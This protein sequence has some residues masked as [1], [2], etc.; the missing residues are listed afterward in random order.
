MDEPNRD[1]QTRVAAQILAALRRRVTTTC[2]VCGNAVQGT[3]KRRYCSDACR[4]RAYR[5]RQQDQQP[6]EEPSR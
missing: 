4:V 6:H 3:T 5:T 1:D 2:V